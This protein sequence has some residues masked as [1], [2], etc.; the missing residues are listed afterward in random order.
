[1]WDAASMTEMCSF[2]LACVMRAAL[3]RFCA[4]QRRRIPN[5]GI[6]LRRSFEDVVFPA[7]IPELLRVL[8]FCN[9]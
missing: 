5:S 7:L 6:S 2:G 4:H 1:M 8:S 9:S 3:V